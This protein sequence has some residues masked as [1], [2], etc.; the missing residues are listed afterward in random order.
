MI[1]KSQISHSND[2]S[3][4]Y[5]RYV[6]IIVK[7]VPKWEKV[8][9][10][11]KRDD[12]FCDNETIKKSVGKAKDVSNVVFSKVKKWSPEWKEQKGRKKLFN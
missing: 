5:L 10:N 7:D 12:V 8:A 6:S 1:E 2:H 3:R 11:N 9:M 4:H